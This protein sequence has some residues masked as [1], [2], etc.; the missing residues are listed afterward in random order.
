MKIERRLINDLKNIGLLPNK[1]L[2]IM[3]PK[4]NKNLER[5]FIRGY[6]DGDGNIY[7]RKN[8]SSRCSIC[9]GSKIFLD[10]LNKKLNKNINTK[11]NNV[12][13][14]INTQCSVIGWGRK[15]DIINLYHYFY[16]DSNFYI[17]R[18]KDIF[19]KS[20]ILSKINN[21]KPTDYWI[22]ERCKKEA[23]KYNKRCDYKKKSKGSY[24]SAYYNKWLD[25]I[26]EHMRKK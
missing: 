22:F 24:N 25:E 9:S 13:N 1:S 20:F 19:H 23:L 2:N 4:I 14:I 6:F 17:R 26:C 11:I 18:K 12:Y 21:R 3:F 16:E 10:E 5:H 15:I 8:K 7:I